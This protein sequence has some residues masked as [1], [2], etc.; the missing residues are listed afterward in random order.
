MCRQ[1]A[2]PAGRRGR[3]RR[4]RRR[5][6]RADRHAAEARRH[7]VPARFHAH[8]DVVAGTQAEHGVFDPVHLLDEQPAERRAGRERAPRAHALGLEGPLLALAHRLSGRARQP[9]REVLDPPSDRTAER[10]REQRDERRSDRCRKEQR[11][12]GTVRPA[13][14]ALD[15]APVAHRPLVEGGQLHQL[16]CQ[17]GIEIDRAHRASLTSSAAGSDGPGSMS[18]TRC[19]PPRRA[20]PRSTRSRDPRSSAGTRPGADARAASAILARSS[21]PAPFPEPS[22]FSRLGRIAEQL[23]RRASRPLRAVDD[24]A[25]HPGLERAAAVELAGSPQRVGEPV[26][27]GLARQ[28]AVAGDRARDLLEVSEPLAVQA[29][30]CPPCSTVAHHPI[31]SDRGRDV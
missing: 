18:P 22:P 5:P 15:V 29:L 21:V 10:R 11:P 23:Q 14:P 28:L 16:R 31:E 2:R 17:H 19:R 7:R 27:H 24:T 25:P 30:D 13:G 4:R 9:R 3:R 26:L 6:E 20:L 8:A 1:S 12:P